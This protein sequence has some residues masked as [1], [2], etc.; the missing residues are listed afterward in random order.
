MK[1]ILLAD[2]KKVGKKDQTVEVSDG[3][4]T[5]FLFPRHLAVQV[6]KKSVEVLADQKEERR[7]EDE[8]NRKAAQELAEKL[9]DI[10]IE[11]R[12]K[13]GKEGKLFGN[14]STKQIEEEL[15][16]QFNVTIDKKKFIDKGPLSVLGYHHL[17]I[18]LYKG[19]IGVINVHLLS[20]GE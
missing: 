12:V 15:L 4:A 3:Y 19:V 18:D 13:T 16:K 9:K 7:L 8:A 6:T 17:K 20:E 11:F 14:I 5:N 10:T 2:V 1:V